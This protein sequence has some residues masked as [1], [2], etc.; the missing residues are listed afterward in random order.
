MT[1]NAVLLVYPGKLGS[2]SVLLLNLLYLSWAFMKEEFH[3][4]ILDMRLQDYENID[5]NNLKCVGITSMTGFPIKYA[6]RFAK[7]VRKKDSSIPIVW[8][9]VY[10]TLLPEQTVSSSYDNVVAR[11]EGEVT[12]IEL[13]NKYARGES[14]KDVSGITF[15]SGG[16][17]KSNPRA[18]IY[19]SKHDRCR[20]LRKDGKTG[21]LNTLL[22]R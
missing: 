20:A 14:I 18:K 17:T 21:F 7:F 3:P 22:S 16:I 19:R 8:E 15:R 2:Y 12:L 9:G 13:V 1:K 10:P 5:L 6:L 11:G 4:Q